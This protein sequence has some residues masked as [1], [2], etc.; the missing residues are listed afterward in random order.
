[1]GSRAK[2][3]HDFSA[4]GEE[5]LLATANGLLETT[6]IGNQPIVSFEELQLVATDLF[7]ALFEVM[8]FAELAEVQRRPETFEDAVHNANTVLDVLGQVLGS[9]MDL[10]E[11]VTSTAVAAGDKAA[12]AYLLR[13]FVELGK[14]T[15][16]HQRQQ[17]EY[18][19]HIHTNAT[20]VVK[21]PP[22]PS[23]CSALHK[24]PQRRGQDPSRTPPPKSCIDTPVRLRA[25]SARTPHPLYQGQSLLARSQP[26]GGVHRPA[27]GP[28]NNEPPPPSTSAAPAV[29]PAA[30]EMRQ[31]GPRHMPSRQRKQGIR[32]SLAHPLVR[33]VALLSP[34][35]CLLPP[36]GI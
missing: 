31:Q 34:A 27:R 19:P 11:C 8:F 13:V 14:V 28:K 2:T 29:H 10:P 4:G 9:T 1:M 23:Q 18:H 33:F 5:R 22:P 25:P 3:A 36:R 17:R 7:V 15:T 24:P 12:I 6:G 20:I 26:R 32:I 21:H 35:L 30:V 16:Q